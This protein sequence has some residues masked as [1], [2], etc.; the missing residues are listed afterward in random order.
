[1]RPRPPLNSSP[2]PYAV[3]L[4][5][6]SRRND[7][8]S[9]SRRRVIVF[10]QKTAIKRQVN[11]SPRFIYAPAIHPEV[12]E[13]P[14]ETVRKG[15]CLCARPETWRDCRRIVHRRAHCWPYVALDRRD[16]RRL[17]LCR[18][19]GNAPFGCRLIRCTE[20]AFDIDTLQ[21]LYVAA[22]LALSS[23]D[24]HSGPGGT[25]DARVDDLIVSRPRHYDESG[26]DRSTRSVLL[27]PA[28]GGRR[29]AL[30]LPMPRSEDLLSIAADLL[31][32]P[33]SS[34]LAER[35]G[36]HPC[37]DRRAPPREAIQ[38]G[39]GASLRSFGG[40]K[41]GCARSSCCRRICR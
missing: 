20:T 31:E 4:L 9:G 36:A 29:A 30:N 33:T 19:A 22:I 28:F 21:T 12:R 27:E 11:V 14:T 32:A 6:E 18:T 17:D 23:P 2:S 25:A 24:G 10:R 39:D 35:A 40:S 41:A 15:C 26:A 1:L 34:S 7:P 13:A 37:G 5:T 8:I 38:I 3:V 16:G